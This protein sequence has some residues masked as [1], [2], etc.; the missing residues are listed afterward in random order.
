MMRNL[1][2]EG[3]TAGNAAL[4][5]TYKEHTG[6]KTGG[7]V[8]NCKSYWNY[9]LKHEQVNISLRVCMYFNTS[10]DFFCLVLFIYFIVLVMTFGNL[11]AYKKHFSILI[12]RLNVL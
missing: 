5:W 1:G 10:L 8:T 9:T 12:K 4:L 6:D 3:R 2:S 7:F 11:V